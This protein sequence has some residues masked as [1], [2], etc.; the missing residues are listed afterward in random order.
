MAATAII[1]SARN[2]LDLIFNLSIIARWTMR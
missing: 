1:A 2:A